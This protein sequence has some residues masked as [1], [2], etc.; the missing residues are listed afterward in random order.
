VL[1]GAALVALW[2]GVG[3]VLAIWFSGRIR[4]W[5]VMTDELL[6]AKLATSIA[7][8]GSPLPSVHGTS[9]AV[10]N[11]LYPLFLAPLYGTLDPPDAF[12]VAHVLNA[13][14]MTSAVFP[15]YLLARQLV[16]R[17]W[18]LAVAALSILVPWMIVTGFLMTEVVAYPAFVWAW[19]GLH[20]AVAQ[21]SPRRDVVAVGALALAVLARTQFAALAFVLPL[22]IVGHEIRYARSFRGGVRASFEQHRLLAAVYALGVVGVLVVALVDSA[23][24]VL[25]VYAVTVERGSLL[26]SGVWSSAAQHL[27]AVAIG[28]GLAPFVLGG[29]WMLASVVR[30][31]TR[32]EHAFATLA[33]LTVVVLTFEVASFSVRFG[34]DLIRDRYLFY[35]VP[36]LLAASA[37]ALATA[38]VR[39]V[40]LGAGAVTL[41]FAATAASLPFTRYPGIS[42]DT[43][44]S[45]L[46]DL[47]VEQSGGL[48]TGTFVAL[49]GLF[50]GLV[51]VLGVLFAPRGPVAVAIG[52]GLVVFS[53]LTLESE[54][55]RAL[56]SSGLSGR[57]LSGEPGIL[58]NWVDAV[59]PEG[60]E[61]ALVAVP[62]S[63]AWDTTAIR[64]WDVEFWNRAVDRAYVTPEGRFSYT[65]FP[66]E[67]LEIDPETGVVA[68]SED[69]PRFHVGAPDDPRFRLAGSR[70]ALNLG[71]AV[72]ELERPYRAIWAASDLEPDGWT[73]P[74]EPAAIR[75][76]EPGAV[77]VQVALRA[78][79]EGAA[80]YEIASG[81]DSRT[82]ELEPGGSAVER[83]DLCV[84]TAS[85]A[86]LRV[87]ATSDA[88][89]PELQLGPVVEGTR[90]VGV[91]V[92]PIEVR[93]GGSA[94]C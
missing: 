17:M 26:P 38:R 76:Y 42:V 93:A 57:P 25:G 79:E 5:S 77:R 71:L 78:P 24:G 11:Q 6:Y 13:F 91:L 39:Y 8:S 47:L 12:R 51:L 55:D 69:A 16:G 56:G 22:A 45:V 54:A 31:R 3:A 27:D 33:L 87:L 21:P 30:A 9:I 7:E 83:F 48:G 28:C 36:L 86:E 60:E 75:V 90:A 64:W 20:L 37:A 62:V 29:G 19:L 68:G 61:V 15:A 34:A 35:V 94:Q 4:D 10:Y 58:L 1:T 89:I 41:F 84:P 82:G 65:P 43:P 74:G 52:A 50:T 40:A 67:T 49:L 14:A 73:R 53:V 66:S 72:R 44:A 81:A 88:R 23:G 85:H 18:S 46:N 63:T 92:G 59:V 80:R 32:E 70:A 2:L